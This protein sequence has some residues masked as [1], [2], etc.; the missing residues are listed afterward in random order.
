MIR[1]AFVSDVHTS[2]GWSLDGR[3]GRYDWLDA[4][5]AN[6]FAQFLAS[7][8]ND[9]SI[10]EVILLGDILDDWVYPI[11]IQPPHYQQIVSAAHIVPIIN[12]LKALSGSEPVVYVQGN[13]DLSITEDQFSSFRDTFFPNISFRDCY[14]TA[15][16]IYAEH[17]HN[18]V[19]W[20]AADPANA[21]PEGHYISR[22][23]ATVEARRQERC[24]QAEVIG[25]IF[26][27]G[28]PATDARMPIK[29]P[30]VNLPL[31]YLAGKLDIDDSETIV[32]VGGNSISLGDVRAMYADLSS[33]W[34]A[35]HGVLDV[36]QSAVREALG[37]EGVADEIATEQGKKVIIFGHTHKKENCYLGQHDAITGAIED[38]Y[39]IYANCGS[40]CNHNDPHP[41]P[42][43]YVVTEYD[44]DNDKH[45]VSLRYWGE[46]REPEVKVI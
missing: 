45:T 4:V 19:M 7:L 46:A 40:W 11:D 16:G 18:H 2:A 17:G 9:A 41:K 5:E 44:E 33:R 21:L 31:S 1:R 13:H 12:N 28:R 35:S 3:K 39:A 8:N 20:N 15:D 24:R 36:V 22:L 38:P 25:T 6:N 27:S 30:M 10:Q 26:S 37:L 34:E 29:D 42:Y 32:T 43:T 14:E 23:A